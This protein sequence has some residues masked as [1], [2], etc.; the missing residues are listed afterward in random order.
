[1]DFPDLNEAL[2]KIQDAAR[3]LNEKKKG[4]HQNT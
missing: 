1:V 3:T 4:F 2:E